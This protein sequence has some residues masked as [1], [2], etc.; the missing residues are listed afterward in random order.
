MI[1]LLWKRG[2][3]TE[4]TLPYWNQAQIT[5]S[6]NYT[7]LHQVEKKYILEET[8]VFEPST[9]S[10]DGGLFAGVGELVCSDKDELFL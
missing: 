6:I 3:T 2:K 9:Q 10:A 1:E 8:Y 5:S 4:I 7:A